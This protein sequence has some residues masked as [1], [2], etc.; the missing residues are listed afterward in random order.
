MVQIIGN[1]KEYTVEG[2]PFCGGDSLT[3]GYG[4]MYD[5]IRHLFGV[6]PAFCSERRFCAVF[7][8]VFRSSLLFIGNQS[9]FFKIGQ[10]S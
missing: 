8:D 6:L 4:S 5:K 3:A 7:F 2:I 1:L 10:D 9:V